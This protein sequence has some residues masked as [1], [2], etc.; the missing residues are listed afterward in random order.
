MKIVQLVK[1]DEEFS[2]QFQ[3]PQFLHY[4]GGV[5]FCP[6]FFVDDV[7]VVVVIFF[8]SLF[9]FFSGRR[10]RPGVRTLVGKKR[11][12]PLSSKSLESRRQ[13][14]WVNEREEEEEEEKQNGRFFAV[15]KKERTR[16]RRVVKM[17]VKITL[18]VHTHSIDKSPNKVFSTFYFILR[19]PWCCILKDTHTIFLCF[20]LG[21]E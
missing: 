14:V 8:P 15:K 10:R 21:W 3:F 20:L 1:E 12:L 5:S 17:Y 6:S 19:H 16:R 2:L 4:G 13:S 18:F 11:L 7:K 9:V